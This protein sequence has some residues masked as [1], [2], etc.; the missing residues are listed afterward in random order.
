MARN[1]LSQI[2]HQTI[3]SGVSEIKQALFAGKLTQ[4]AENETN[5]LML[6][7]V[8]VDQLAGADRKTISSFY[9]PITDKK[10]A[11]RF[12][13]ANLEEF[14]FWAWRSC[15]IVALQMILQTEIPRLREKTT[16]DFIQE[17]LA[18]NGYNY[19]NDVGWYHHALAQLARQYGLAA[20]TK[21]FVPLSQIAWEINKG[22]Y[23]LISVISQHGGHFLLGFQS[24]LDEKGQLTGLTVHDP[25]NYQK[26]GEGQ[27]ITSD[28]LNKISTKRIISIS[29]LKKQNG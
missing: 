17:G 28:Q 24:H 4:T 25:N 11:K 12:G 19:V 13:A 15:G 2:F 22:N 26:T 5:K 23:V 20:K 6:A 10:A 21:K 27:F 14:S 7:P 3:G 1:E 16:M 9:G 18:L 29:F 8:Y